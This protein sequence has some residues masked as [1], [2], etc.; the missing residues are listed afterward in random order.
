MGSL[1][2]YTMDFAM[3]TD[4]VKDGFSIYG[5]TTLVQNAR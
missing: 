3:A 2:V 4:G 5:F 1:T